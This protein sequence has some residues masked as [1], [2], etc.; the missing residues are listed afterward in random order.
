MNLA[1]R[2]VQGTLGEWSCGCSR[3]LDWW[4][5]NGGCFGF[6]IGLTII[7]IVNLLILFGGYALGWYLAEWIW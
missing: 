3:W 4:G 2:V 7:V 1:E 5:N 6:G